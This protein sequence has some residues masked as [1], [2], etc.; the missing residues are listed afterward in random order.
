[1]GRVTFMI[2]PRGSQRY[3]LQKNLDVRVEKYFIIAGKYQLGAFFDVFN[4]F[5]EAV[6]TSWGTRINYDWYTDGPASTSGH[7]LYGL[8]LPRRA[9][10]GIRLIF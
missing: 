5:N 8:N 4:V 7:D 9:R 6:I 10:L 3:P 1:M 2:E